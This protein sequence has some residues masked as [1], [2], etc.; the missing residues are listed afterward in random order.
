MTGPHPVIMFLN[1]NGFYERGKAFVAIN[2][3]KYIYKHN[4]V[5]FEKEHTVMAQDV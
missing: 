1:C 3:L 2:V 4:T 5:S